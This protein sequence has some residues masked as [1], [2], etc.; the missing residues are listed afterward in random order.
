[1]NNSE[2]NFRMAVVKHVNLLRPHLY[3]CRGDGFDA[4]FDLR[5]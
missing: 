2:K 1:M 5:F 4:V 3:F